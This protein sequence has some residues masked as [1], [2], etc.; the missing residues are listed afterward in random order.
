M[1]NYNQGAFDHWYNSDRLAESRSRLASDISTGDRIRRATRSS[2]SKNKCGVTT[3]RC[4]YQ[5]ITGH[6]QKACA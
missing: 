5:K 2:N 4:L 1:T 6:L 3:P